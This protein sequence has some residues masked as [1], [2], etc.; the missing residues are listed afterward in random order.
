MADVSSLALGGSFF[1]VV[2]NCLC[3]IIAPTIIITKKSREVILYIF[4]MG[5]LIINILSS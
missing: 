5:V 3:H 2:L 1:C 4:I